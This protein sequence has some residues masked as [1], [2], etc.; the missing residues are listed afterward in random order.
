V[1]SALGSDGAF[2]VEGVAPGDH[3]AELTGEGMTC[4]V[5]L[6]VPASSEPV[7]RTGVTTCSSVVAPG[8]KAAR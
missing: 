2:Y 7:I 5:T 1:A 6:H 3:R 8:G 4:V